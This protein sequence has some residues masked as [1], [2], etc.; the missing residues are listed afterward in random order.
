MKRVLMYL[1]MLF[2]V[3]GMS[4]CGGG[5]QSAIEGKLVDWKGKPVAGVK[6]A[7]TQIQ[8]IKGYEKF[9][10]A[11]K[12]DGTFTLKGVFPSSKYILTPNSEKWN[13]NLEV[14]INT[15]P[16]GETAIV[17][18]TM[19]IKQ[20]YTKTQNPV[21]ADIATGNP[22]KS[23]CSGQLVD[24]NNKPITGVKI[25]AS[26]NHP[27]QGFE[28]FETTTG[29]NGT[30]HFSTLLPSS[31][32]TFK[33]VSDKWNTEA[34]T[35]IET[36]PHHGDEV[37]LPKPLVIKQVM[38]KSEP[39]QVA[40]IATGSPGKT[41]LTGKLL[42][43]KN[44]PIAGVK[45]L[46]SL[47]RPIN[48]KGYEQ[49]EE[50]TGSDGSFRFT[51]LL[52]ISKYE[53]KPVSD[54]WTTEVVVAIDTP[55]HSGDSVSLTNPM[56]ISRAFLKN[57]CSLISD[58]I[59][60]KK[61]F[62]LSPDGVI[63]DAETGLEWIVGPDK[64]INFEQAEDWVKKCSIAGGGWRMPTTVELH[65]IYQR[66]AEKCFGLQKQHFG[67]P[68]DLD[69]TIFKTTGYFVWATSEA[70]ARQPAKQYNFNQGREWT[71]RRDQTHK[72]RVFAVRSSR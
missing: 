25:V 59:T 69:P 5:N 56:V 22:G 62:T 12:A 17:P 26:L 51:G 60:T 50:T 29:E 72:Q 7:A 24:W 27:V 37:S 23:S 18:G 30:F 16:K 2:S 65:A 70:N 46:A 1:F 13:C 61:R 39:P 43:W 20:V 44:R 32:Y 64:D 55:Q 66:D 6:I 71:S 21:I 35:S 41:L 49:F 45:I 67:D 4:A 53:L 38:T 34:S 11:T 15:A 54:K 8:P 48:V 57:S 58:L 3:W 10:A 28:K 36:P 31:R 40:D 68:V 14:S 33:P 63:T 9:D 42:D 19:V 47:K 52:P